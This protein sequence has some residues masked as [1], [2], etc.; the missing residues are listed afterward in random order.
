MAL[1]IKILSY[2]YCGL[3]QQTKMEGKTNVFLYTACFK[4]TIETCCLFII[5]GYTKEY[6]PY[7]NTGIKRNYSIIIMLIGTIP[8][9]FGIHTIIGMTNVI[10]FTIIFDLNI[11]QSQSLFFYF[12]ITCSN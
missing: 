10:I 8:A 3:I 12:C 4:N 7:Q 11:N 5:G 1:F 2:Y 9:K 6:C